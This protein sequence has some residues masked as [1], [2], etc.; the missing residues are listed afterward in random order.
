MQRGDKKEENLAGHSDAENLVSH[1]PEKHFLVLLMESVVD[2]YNY[3]KFYGEKNSCSK[4][5]YLPIWYC[6]IGSYWY[7]ISGW[8]TPYEQ[9]VLLGTLFKTSDML[10]SSIRYR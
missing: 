3:Q 7:L 4:Y 9:T 5:L 6:A 10:S 1:A 2:K 8:K